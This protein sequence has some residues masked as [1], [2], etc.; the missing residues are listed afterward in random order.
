MC[1]FSHLLISQVSLDL[2][3]PDQV[4]HVYDGSSTEK[5]VVP[6]VSTCLPSAA[7]HNS[8]HL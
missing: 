2:P 5:A 8:E 1:N 6:A 4:M 3:R 7:I